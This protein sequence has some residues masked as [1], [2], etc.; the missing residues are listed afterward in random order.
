M[1]F[2]L[3]IT[4]ELTDMSLPGIWRVKRVFWLP[5]P[6]FDV[7]GTLVCRR[8]FVLKELKGKTQLNQEFFK[9]WPDNLDSSISRHTQIIDIFAD[10]RI[11]CL[12]DGI[13]FI[14]VL[15]DCNFWKC[16]FPMNHNVCL[17]VVR[18]LSVW[19]VVFILTT[20]QHL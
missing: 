4:I 11:P 18:S 1:R 20:H 19:C 15:V 8:R 14:G 5:E 3:L 7:M 6:V 13:K 16:N 2:L 10:I 17:S 12:Q 9:N